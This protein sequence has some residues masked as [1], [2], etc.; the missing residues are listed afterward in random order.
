MRERGFA[1]Y[2]WGVLGFNLLVVLWGAYVRA[3]ARGRGAGGHWPLCN[4]EVLPRSAQVETLVEFTHRVTSGL[5]LAGGGG[6]PA[7]GGPRLSAGAPRPAGGDALDGLHAAGGAGGGGAGALALVAENASMARAFWMIAHLINTFLL[8]GV[9]RADGVVGLGGRGGAVARGAARLALGAG[10]SWGCSL[11]G[12][13]GAIAALGDTLF[14]SRS[15]AEGL[16][17]DLSADGAPAAAAAQVYHPLLALAVAAR[18][19]RGWGVAPGPP[20]AGRPC[21]LARGLSALAALQL[22]GGGGERGAPRPVGLQ[23]LHLL[24]ADLVWITLRAARARRASAD[25]VPREVGGAAVGAAGGLGLRLLGEGGGGGGRGRRCCRRPGWS[26]P[27]AARRGSPPSRREM[28]RPS[29]VPL[30][31]GP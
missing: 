24:L 22:A 27:P 10:G 19:W 2:A 9:A 18:Y 14:P 16:R 17:Q 11:L 23:L 25:E 5:A 6:A 31:S 3:T 12:A 20:H 26:R 8:I 15:L 30:P 28:G 13:S 4:G 29:P 1:G 7:V 21:R